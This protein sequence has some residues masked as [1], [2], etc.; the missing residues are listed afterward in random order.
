MSFVLLRIHIFEDKSSA[1]LQLALHFS[2]LTMNV[3]N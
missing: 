3:N 2:K 1:A